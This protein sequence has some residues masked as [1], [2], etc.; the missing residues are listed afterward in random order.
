[1]RDARE[2]G[3]ELAGGMPGIMVEMYREIIIAV[4]NEALE[5]AVIAARDVCC[6]RTPYCRRPEKC[7]NGC[8]AKTIAAAIR[9]MKE[10]NDAEG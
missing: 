5:G 6:I 4:R 7:V 1:M 10:A 9:A 8:G 2:W 3:K